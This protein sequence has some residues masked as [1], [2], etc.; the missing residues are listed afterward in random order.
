MEYSIDIN[1]DMGESYGNFQIGNDAALMP[2]ISSCNIACGYHGGDP[3]TILKTI[4]LAVK[5]NLQIGAHPSYPDLAGFGRRSMIMSNV[6]LHAMLLYQISAL[7]KMAE[8]EGAAL[9]Y[10]KPHGALYHAISHQVDI[11]KIAFIVAERF[12]LPLMVLAGS[13]TANWASKQNKLHIKESF[14]D[15]RYEADGRLVSR[16]KP[17]AVIKNTKVATQQFLNL[18]LHKKVRTSPDHELSVECDS[19]CIHG[20]NDAALEILQAV[21]RVAAEENIKINGVSS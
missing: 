21:S 4:R 1:C 16:E 3:A 15:R 11:A 9:K 17:T 14:L 18:V 13:D 7:L 12:Q 20:D 5:H 2:Y 19:I 6:D 8:L 10:I